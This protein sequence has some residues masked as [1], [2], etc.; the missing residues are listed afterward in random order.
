MFFMGSLVQLVI[1]VSI[2]VVV[3]FRPFGLM[4]KDIDLGI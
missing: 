1:F 2:M 4:G 3:Y